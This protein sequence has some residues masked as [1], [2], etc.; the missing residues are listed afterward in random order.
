[1]DATVGH[2]SSL[3]VMAPLLAS[4]AALTDS[5]RIG[6]KV[7]L[8]F[9]AILREPHLRQHCEGHDGQLAA[10]FVRTEKQRIS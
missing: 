3:N 6:Q 8:F 5:W 7:R 4:N 10:K 9:S 1:M 2:A